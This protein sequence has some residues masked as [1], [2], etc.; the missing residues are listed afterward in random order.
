ML[1]IG[2]LQFSPVLGDP[3][4]TIQKLTALLPQ[5]RELDLLVLPEL[6]NSGYNFTS[7]D[8]AWD[9]A[10]SV[11]DSS[12]LDFLTEM[13]QEHNF[14]IVSGFNERQSDKLFNSAVLVGPEGY[15]GKYQKL[16]LFYNEKEF[17]QPGEEGLPVFDIGDCKIGIQVCFDWMYPEAWRILAL[18]GAEVICHTSNLVLPG[19]AQRAVPI[20]ALINR[21]YTITANRVGTEGDLTFTGLSTI[22]DTRGN[23]LGQASATGEELLTAEID[24]AAARDKQITSK[25]HLFK[26]RRPQDYTLLTQNDEVGE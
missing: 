19:L 18:K 6:C 23:V 17:F 21:V 20:H 16:H 7:K 9:T 3:P 8:Q 15:L 26:D 1:K 5:A 10:E 22:A 11:E 24:P 14:H 25:N 13:S 2:C 4:A 12:F